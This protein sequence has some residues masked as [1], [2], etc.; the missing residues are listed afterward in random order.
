ML[1]IVAEETSAGES[2][3]KYAD[4]PKLSNRQRK[5][6]E[7]LLNMGFVVD[8]KPDLQVAQAANGVCL[9]LLFL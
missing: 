3:T 5:R 9:G 7:R 8:L 1:P 2:S 6:R 4:V